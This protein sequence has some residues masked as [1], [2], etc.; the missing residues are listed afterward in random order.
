MKLSVNQTISV[1]PEWMNKGSLF[2]S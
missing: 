2:L 1:L